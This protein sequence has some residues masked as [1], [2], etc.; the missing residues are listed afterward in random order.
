MECRRTSWIHYG[1]LLDY[2]HTTEIW[3]NLTTVMIRNQIIVPCMT[4]KLSSWYSAPMRCYMTS[5][6][7]MY[8]NWN[9]SRRN[10]ASTAHTHTQIPQLY[11]S[12]CSGVG[13][14]QR[15]SRC[16]GPC[17][18]CHKV[19]L[20]PQ[21]SLSCNSIPREFLA[22]CQHRTRS[23]SARPFQELCTI[24]CPLPLLG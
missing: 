12:S 20:P 10:M 15:Y 14:R 19:H 13:T 4:V 16:G 5:R 8:L 21:I 17:R 23:I 9:R 7:G 22:K 1:P 24:D 3:Q 2:Y 6:V 18:I 11:V